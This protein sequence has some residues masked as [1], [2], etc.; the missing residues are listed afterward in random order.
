MVQLVF[1]P[2]AEQVIERLE[3]QDP[4]TYQ[5]AIDDIALLEAIG[6]DAADFGTMFAGQV[7]LLGPTG[8]VSYWVSPYSDHYWLIESIDVS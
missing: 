8:R 5:V 7:Y 2:E 6:V 4:L 1:T 3:Q